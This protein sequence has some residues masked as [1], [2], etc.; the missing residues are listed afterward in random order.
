V[1]I[2]IF[3]GIA[4]GMLLYL[5]SVGLSITLGLMNFVNLAHGAFAMIGGYAASLAMSRLGVPFPLALLVAFAAGGVAGAVLERVLFARLYS[6]AHLDQLLLTIGLVFVC[7]AAATYLFGPTMQVFSLPSYLDGQ[8]RVLDLDVGRYRLFLV[9]VGGIVV[10]SLAALMTQ[11]KF[12]AMVRACVDNRRVSAGLGLPVGRVY[13]L[14]FALGCGLAGF[15]GA[16]GLGMLSLDPTFPLKYL[17]YFLIV[18]CVGGAGT[19]SGPFLAALLVGVVD[20][21]SKYYLP[22]LGAF[23]IYVFMVVL[24]LFRPYGLIP[25]R[26]VR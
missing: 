21:A 15:G 22:Q 16:L 18:V 1:A 11:T 20:V 4:Y 17:I 23:V 13:L 7:V 8:V 14:A 26:G 19:L 3:D 10:L 6:S 12:G 5:I 25:R 9:L 2:V 24:L